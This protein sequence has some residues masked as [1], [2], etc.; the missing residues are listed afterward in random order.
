MD[1]EE[2]LT[3]VIVDYMNIRQVFTNDVARFPLP[4]VRELVSYLHDHQ[5]H[6]I[7]MVDPAVAYVTEDYPPYTNGVNAD[8]FLKN[9]NGSIY[10]GVVWVCADDALDDLVKPVNRC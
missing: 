7:V 8:A 2:F 9:G 5:Q 1:S 6:Y 3:L 10:Q 4:L